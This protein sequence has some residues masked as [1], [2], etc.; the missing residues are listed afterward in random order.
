M[1]LPKRDGVYY[2]KRN[3]FNLIKLN[4]FD[5]SNCN[6]LISL[7]TPED[8]DMLMKINIL[9]WEN[10]LFTICDKATYES[11]N[12]IRSGINGFNQETLMFDP[13]KDYY[14]PLDMTAVRVRTNEIARII[15]FSKMKNYNYSTI[16]ETTAVKWLKTMLDFLLDTSNEKYSIKDMATLYQVV[17]DF[18]KGNIDEKDLISKDE[19][20]FYK[21]QEKTEGGDFRASVFALISLSLTEFKDRLVEKEN[22]E[23][24]FSL[25]N[26]FITRN[27]FEKRKSFYFM[28]EKEDIERF[29][30][31]INLM[32]FDFYVN[33]RMTKNDKMLYIFNSEISEGKL[34]VDYTILQDI[35]EKFKIE[36][37]KFLIFQNNINDFEEKH[38]FFDKVLKY[39]KKTKKNELIE[40]KYLDNLVKI[41]EMEKI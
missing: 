39:N 31:L 38:V 13:L 30:I 3:V 18:W 21:E 20:E 14:N 41:T 7:E 10:N 22:T 26:S 29:K 1:F 2:G 36:N 9:N 19:K 8:N 40:K 33:F 17:D 24:H 27:F 15:I 32:I 35:K 11:T 12:D 37:N 34:L 6:T 5:K 23:N 25:K 4:T 28:V 16:I